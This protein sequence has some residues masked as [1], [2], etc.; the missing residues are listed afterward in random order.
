VYFCLR[1]RR[2]EFIQIEGEIWLSLDGLGLAPG[3]SLY[4]QGVKVTKTKKSAGFNK[5]VFVETEVSRMGT[6]R[7]LVYSN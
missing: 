7:G 1:L 3:V 2:D 5:R 6:G 4:F